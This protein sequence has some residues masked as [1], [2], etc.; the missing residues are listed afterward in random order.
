MFGVGPEYWSHSHLSSFRGCV[1]YILYEVLGR[2]FFKREMSSPLEE[3]HQLAIWHTL[4]EELKAAG[5]EPAALADVGGTVS[6]VMLAYHIFLVMDNAELPESIV[7]R[8]RS[9]ENFQGARYEINVAAMMIVAGYKI[10]WMPHS[11]D[12]AVEFIA[13]HRD[14]RRFAVEAKSKH[15]LGVL[16][17]GV[18]NSPEPPRRIDFQHLI[19]RGVRKN[20]NEPLLLFVEANIPA[21]FEEL[22]KRALAEMEAAWVKK[23]DRRV[24][25][26]QGFPCVGIL[27][28]NE[29][30]AWNLRDKLKTGSMPGWVWTC[31]GPHRHNFDATPYLKELAASSGLAFKVPEISW[32]NTNQGIPDGPMK[33]GYVELLE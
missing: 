21:A 1:S 15:R 30:L 19:S 8:L 10:E 27:V 22:D 29:S 32:Q 16:K 17:P 9:K 3:R 23:I 31:S 26:E 7:R 18:I 11:P 28:T 13:T 20:P 25:G 12:S 14:G 5:G 6:Y 4:Y 2:D 33:D 24:W